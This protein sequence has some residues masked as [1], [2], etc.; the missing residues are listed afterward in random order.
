MVV[1]SGEGDTMP[2]QG[3]GWQD[4]PTP[5]R[6][7]SSN[8]QITGTK[9]QGPNLRNNPTLFSSPDGLRSEDYTELASCRWKS[10]CLV[11]RRAN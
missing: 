2:D 7:R 11:E 9:S 6:Q 8:D 10:S 5:K 3:V 4:A 1:E